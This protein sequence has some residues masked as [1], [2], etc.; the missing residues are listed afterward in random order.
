MEGVVR[1]CIQP[2]RSVQ[3]TYL[4]WES[5]ESARKRK[6]KNKRGGCRGGALQLSLREQHDGLFIQERG[7]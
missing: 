4:D 2:L 1:L 7:G 3:C 5:G 6:D